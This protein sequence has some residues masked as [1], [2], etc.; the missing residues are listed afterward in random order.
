MRVDLHNIADISV[1]IHK[2]DYDKSGWFT[3]GF[4]TR[5]WGDAE[6]K[7]SDDQITMF[8]EHNGNIEDI[9]SALIDHLQKGMSIA[10]LDHADRKEKREAEK[11]AEEASV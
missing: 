11:K 5:S 10:R 6:V 4:K 3:L 2:S 7:D 9:Y 8:T 1:T